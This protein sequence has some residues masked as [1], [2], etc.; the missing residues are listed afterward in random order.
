MR[1]TAQTRAAGRTVVKPVGDAILRGAGT[2]KVRG[3]S[4]KKGT[5]TYDHRSLAFRKQNNADPGPK[6]V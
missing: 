1:K 2:A 4:E 3:G 6:N 5:V